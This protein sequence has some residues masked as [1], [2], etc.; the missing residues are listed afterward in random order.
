LYSL[1]N[2]W[3]QAVWL[4]WRGGFVRAPAGGWGV[5]ATGVGR[6]GL[7]PDLRGWGESTR[8][9]RKAS[10]IGGGSGSAAV[11]ASG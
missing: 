1:G 2:P 8:I 6:V 11:G 10:G 5:R 7:K 4:T 3:G 9:E